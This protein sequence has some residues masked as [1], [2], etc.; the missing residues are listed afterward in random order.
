VISRRAAV[1]S[2]VSIG[3]TYTSFSSSSLVVSVEVVSDTL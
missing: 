3:A 2:M 1:P